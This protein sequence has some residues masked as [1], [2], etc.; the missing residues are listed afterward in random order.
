MCLNIKN[1]YQNSLLSKK[2]G[3]ISLYNKIL[4]AY[5]IDI[6]KWNELS[7]NCYDLITKKFNREYVDNYNYSS[8]YLY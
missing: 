4:E 1:S 2:I 6:N 5:N 8:L 7:S 3:K